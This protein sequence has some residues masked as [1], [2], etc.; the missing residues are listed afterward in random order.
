MKSL[1]DDEKHDS[2]IKGLKAKD[3]PAE[4]RVSKRGSSTSLL[5]EKSGSKKGVEKGVKPKKGQSL[6]EPQ[7]NVLESNAVYHPLMESVEHA[8]DCSLLIKGNL[9][10]LALDLAD[11][12][13]GDEGVQALQ[14]AVALQASFSAAVPSMAGAAGGGT[15]GGMRGNV[16]GLMRLNLGHNKLIRDESTLK[17]IEAMLSGKD[18]AARTGPVIMDGGEIK[19]EQ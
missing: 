1:K 3:S 13:I 8:L 10:L 11:N 12:L 7:P 6:S 19:H 15:E 5:T 14:R 18:P 9:A 17:C 16:T 2:K 4:L